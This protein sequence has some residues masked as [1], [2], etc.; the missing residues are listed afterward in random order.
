LPIARPHTADEAFANLY[1]RHASPPCFDLAFN[2]TA[3]RQL[4]VDGENVELKT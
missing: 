2:A 1:L 4:S 3:R